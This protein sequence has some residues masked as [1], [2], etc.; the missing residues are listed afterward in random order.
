MGIRGELFSVKMVC[1]ERTYFFNVKENRLGDLFL[2]IVESKE[3]ELSTYERHS[4]VVFKENLD[5][6][7]SQLTKA[8]DT[9]KKIKPE[10]PLRQLKHKKDSD[11]IDATHSARNH[12]AH[13]APAHEQLKKHVVHIKKTREEKREP[14]KARVRT[15]NTDV[16]Q[17]NNKHTTSDTLQNATDKSRI[18]QTDPITQEHPKN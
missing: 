11:R 9:M 7:M 3:S 1:D 12:T 4:V 5:E 14:K 17:S 15:F 16:S 18:L 10:K 13:P 8:A 6:F 2:T